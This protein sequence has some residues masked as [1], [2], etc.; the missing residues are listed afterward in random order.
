MIGQSR[1]QKAEGRRQQALA[2]F[3]LL[4]SAFCLLLAAC[5]WGGQPPGGG[6]N[7]TPSPVLSPQATGE[8]QQ[9]PCIAADLRAVA[10]WQGA[11]GG[12]AG[13]VSFINKSDATCALRGRPGI[14]LVDANGGLMPV[15]NVEYMEQPGGDGGEGGGTPDNS[16]AENS[17]PVVL[18]PGAKSFVYFEWRNWCGQAVG[19]FKLAVALPDAGGQLTVPVQ[20]PQGAPLS[21]T[22]RCDDPGTASTISIGQFK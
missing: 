11:V 1:R 18:G 10:G 22:P 20:D 15:A 21:S 5:D 7:A 13:G 14:H 16:A 9:A 2:A 17:G 8:I 19:P 4:P 3:C 6:S 12:M